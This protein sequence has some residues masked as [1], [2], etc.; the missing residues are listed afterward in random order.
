MVSRAYLY[1]NEPMPKKTHGRSLRN[2]RGVA[3]C[4]NHRRF[5]ILWTFEYFDNSWKTSGRLI[6]KRPDAYFQ[7]CALMELLSP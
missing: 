2:H 6:I 5:L 1:S 3:A 7:A 4:S